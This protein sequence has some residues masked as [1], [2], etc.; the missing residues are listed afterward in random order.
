MH[1]PAR[2]LDMVTCPPPPHDWALGGGLPYSSLYL[3]GT[4]HPL[5]SEDGFWGLP[6][7]PLRPG[8]RSPSNLPTVDIVAI[9]TETLGAVK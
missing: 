4:G 7:L 8:K 9:D 6:T 5:S 1:S 3:G 2:A